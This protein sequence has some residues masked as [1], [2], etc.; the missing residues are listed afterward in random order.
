M[1]KIAIEFSYNNTCKSKDRYWASYY[2]QEIFRKNGIELV[3][4]SINKYNKNKKTFNEYNY[5]DTNGLIKRVQKPY[6][7]KI[8]W[9]RSGSSTV[10]KYAL[11][12]TFTIISSERIAVLANDKYETYMFLKKYQP[13]TFLLS[14]VLKNNS[15]QHKYTWPMVLKPI[16]ASGWNWIE[17]TTIQELLNE[18]EKYIGVEEL[19]IVQ[20]FKNFSEGYPWIV[21]G[22]H[23]VRFM[24][25]GKKIVEITLRVPEK[26]NFK[27]NLWSGWSQSP[28][29]KKNVPLK[30]INLAK[31]IYKEITPEQQEIFSIDFAFCKSENKRYVLEI[32]ASPGTRYYQTDKKVLKTICIWLVKFFKKIGKSL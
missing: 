8:I 23:D 20:E 7:P 32:N 15:I 10:Y 30:L 29:D 6:K 4:V 17:L 1:L 19:F 16:R 21:E 27:S 18:R 2:M 24:F 28:L 26:W 3:R 9:N 22:N 14:S 5:Y 12:K 25:A 31:K 13:K 11:L